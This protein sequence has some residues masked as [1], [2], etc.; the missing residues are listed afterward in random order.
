MVTSL[1]NGLLD[2]PVSLTE[3]KHKRGRRRTWRA[4]GADGATAIVK[5]YA[6]DRAPVV[7]ARVAALRAGPRPP[8]VPEVLHADPARHLVVLTDVPGAPLGDAVLAGDQDGCRHAGEALGAWHGW[9]RGRSPVPLR[10]HTAARELEVLLRR[11]ETAPPTIGPTVA[12]MAP[13]L[14]EPWPCPTVVHRDLYEDQVL[15]G[16]GGEVGLIDLDDAALGPAELDVGNLIAHLDLLALRTGRS[17]DQPRTE[18]LGGYLSAG[19]PL[20]RSLLARC[21]RLSL[22]RLACIHAEPRL[23]ELA[24]AQWDSSTPS[25]RKSAK[26]PPAPGP[27]KTTDADPAIPAEPGMT[28]LRTLAGSMETARRPSR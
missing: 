21:R 19:A 26:R 15:L 18:L 27:T 9:W 4:T 16:A 28:T 5:V 25:S 3:L 12:R 6:S 14:A 13:R 10:P 8:R 17:V 1:P 23:L 20:D 2:P 7:A 11:A 24:E 22:L